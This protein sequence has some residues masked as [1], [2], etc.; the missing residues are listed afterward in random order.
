MPFNRGTHI[1]AMIDE[2]QWCKPQS[3]LDVGAGW[4]LWG[5]IFRAFTDGRGMKLKKSDWTCKVDAIEYFASYG[6]DNPAWKFYNNVYIGDAMTALDKLGKYDVVFCGDMIEHL[7]KEDGHKLVEK[8]RE[9]ANAW[10]YVATPMPAR[11]Q[12]SMLGNEKETHLSDWT[13]EDFKAYPYELVG[14]IGWGTDYM[15][16]VRIRPK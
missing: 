7:S 5:P 4:G 13:E 14:K 3:I 9:H 11:P 2:I 15:L 16:C 10:V 1:S 12:G 8:M 6:D